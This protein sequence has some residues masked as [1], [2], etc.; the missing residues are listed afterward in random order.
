MRAV[1]RSGKDRLVKGLGADMKNEAPDLAC[2][3]AHVTT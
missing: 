2:P 1:N 3:K